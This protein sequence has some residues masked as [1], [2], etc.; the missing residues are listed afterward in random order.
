MRTGEARGFSFVELVVSAAIMVAVT[1]SM[2]GLVR[3]ARTVFEIDRERTDMQQRV[4]VSMETMFRDLVM[5]GAGMQMPAIAPFRRGLEN[6]DVPGAVFSDRIS[7]RYVPHDASAADAVTVTYAL[8]ADQAGALQLARYDG[9]STELPVI[10]Q[11]AGLRFEYFD[12]AGQPIAIAAFADGPWV[13]NGVAPDRFDA[14]LQAVRRVRVQLRVRPT[15]S[16]VGVPLADLDV[17]MDVAPRNL[18]LP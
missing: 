2:V 7:A 1:G 13:P 9:R 12:A 18:N 5:A 15:R 11:V 8:R 16:F 6:A 3:A 14:D 10:D 4:R 17:Q